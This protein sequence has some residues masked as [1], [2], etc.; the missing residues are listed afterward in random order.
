MQCDET[1]TFECCY[2]PSVEENKSEEPEIDWSGQFFHE[3]AKELWS[4]YEETLQY[5]HEED[6]NMGDIAVE[7]DE[8]NVETHNDDKRSRGDEVEGLV[9]SNY[10]MEDQPV[11]NAEIENNRVN[12]YFG[13]G[14]NFSRLNYSRDESNLN[15]NMSKIW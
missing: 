13:F 9:E 5:H 11:S 8:V 10:K 14:D 15:S 4:D 7:E 2:V 1:Q 3:N 6:Q 12:F